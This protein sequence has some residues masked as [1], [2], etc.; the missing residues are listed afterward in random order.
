MKKLKFRV[1]LEAGKTVIYTLSAI[2]RAQGFNV[3]VS[4]FGAG[5]ESI[6]YLGEADKSD[7]VGWVEEAS[8]G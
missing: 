8:N 2:S 5:V 7:I 3:A 4:A 6:T 1:V